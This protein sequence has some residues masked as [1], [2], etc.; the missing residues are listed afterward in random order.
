MIRT[1]IDLEV[2]EDLEELP[3][4]IPASQEMGFHQVT[5][6]PLLACASRDILS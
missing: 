6:I 3:D 4:A 5:T 2:V 1:V